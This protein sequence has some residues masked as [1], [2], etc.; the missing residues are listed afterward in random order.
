MP[1]SIDAPQSP[2]VSV[3][4]PN[5]L[6][7]CLSKSWGGL[8]MYPAQ[9]AAALVRQ[10]CQV[11]GAALEGTAVADSFKKA[12]LSHLTFGS[13]WRALLTVKKTLAYIRQHQ[14][15]VIHA[16]KSGDM[17]LAAFLV[18]LAPDLKL[19]FTD[20]MGVSMSKKD[21]LHR[22]MYSKVTR[23]F[24]ISR[25]THA[26]NL[27]AFPLPAERIT[28]L[29]NGIDL[30]PY[31]PPS[32]LEHRQEVR[33]ITL[34]VPVD[35]L[36]LGI[37]GRINRGKGQIQWVQALAVLVKLPLTV[38]WH[39]VIVGEATGE[40]ALEGGYK[41]Q[42]IE[43]IEALG[44]TSR[45]TLAGFQSEM[46]QCLQAIDIA[47]IASHNEAFGLS[48]IEAMAAG[49]AVVGANSGAIPELI[50]ADVGLLVNPDDSQAFADALAALMQDDERRHGLGHRAR[51]HA[52]QNF[53]MDAY[54]TRL[55]EYYRA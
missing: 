11:H 1:R 34:K 13:Q 41:A 23:L 44:L 29:Y 20:H 35:G 47:A 32:S 24:S 46:A 10:G 4:A 15:T 8:E 6:Q 39:A 42:L 19:F 38:Q 27:N 36:L 33:R 50:K 25:A 7:I 49:C 17:R 48:V 16:H 9:L 18:Q 22:W 43:R 51:E 5:V 28:M 14:I 45:V 2:L 26:R 37:P 12:G 54:V 52:L 40:D 31:Q 53:G 30:R 21:W 55:L 3:P